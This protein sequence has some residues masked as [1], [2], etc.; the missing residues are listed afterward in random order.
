MIHEINTADLSRLLKVKNV[1]IIDVRPT[2]A[3]NG[4]KLGRE[5]RRGHIAGAKSLPAKWLKYIDWIEIVRHKNILPVH[6]IVVYGYSSQETLE[7]AD[8]FQKSGYKK[9]FVYHHFVDEWTCHIG[10]PMQNLTR[11]KNLV[12]AEWVNELIN[13]GRPQEYENDKFVIVH[14]HYRNRDA[15]LSGHIPGAIDMDTLALEAP[16]TWNRRS[17]QE[18]KAALEAH[19]ITADTTVVLYGKYMFPDNKDAFPGSAAGDIGAVRNALIMMYAGVN[20][21]RILNGGFQSWQDAGFKIDFTDIPKTPV[22][23]FGVVIPQK[24]ELFVD[25]PQ[26]KEMLVSPKAELVCVRSWPEYI[27]EVSGYNYIEAKGR[28]PGAVFADC[29]SDAYHMENY[30]N[31]DHTT[32]EYHEIA[33]IWM[34]N[35]ITPDK[36]LAFYCGTGWRG[37]EAWFNAWLMGWPHVSVYDGGWFEWSN[38]PKNPIETGLPKEQPQSF[39]SLTPQK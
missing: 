26:A 19:G 39:K 31:V 36:H 15:Y 38:D 5:K 3:Y 17:P 32:R 8:R 34:L 21:V 11:Y 6:D 22:K 33:D 20:D 27:G 35:G 16:E 18:L 37:S 2:E 9:V 4:W 1:K 23:D 12:S 24:P 29:G 14:S 30:R 13:G 7:V 10:L 28:I 25:T